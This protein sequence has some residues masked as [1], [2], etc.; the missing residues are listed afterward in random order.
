MLLYR[1]RKGDPEYL[2]WFN[3]LKEGHVLFDV[4]DHPAAVEHPERA[5]GY[6]ALI[7]P[8]PARAPAAMLRAA[9]ESGAKL[10]FSGLVDGEATE[11]L[12]LLGVEWR[13]PPSRT[14]T[15]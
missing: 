3:L 15:G 6:A 9:R 11:A 2:R 1:P 5:A 14:A 10:L 8:D 13:T 12:R 4:L 7:V